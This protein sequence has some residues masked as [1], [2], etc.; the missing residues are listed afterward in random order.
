MQRLSLALVGLAQGL[1][2][3]WCA[4]LGWEALHV[5]V[6]VGIIGALSFTAGN[7]LPR[8]GAA[9]K[10]H[11]RVSADLAA[12]SGVRSAGIRVDQSSRL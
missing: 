6:L 4:V 3:L 9:P 2:T 7:P 8:T 12:I 11:D 1:T 5:I 10:T